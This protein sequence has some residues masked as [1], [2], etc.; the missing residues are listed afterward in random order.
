MVLHQYAPV[1][2]LA[3][4]ETRHAVAGPAHGVAFH[5]NVVRVLVPV[6]QLTHAVL[7]CQETIEDVA[8]AVG[9]CDVG[10]KLNQLDILDF[11]AK[12]LAHQDVGVQVKESSKVVGQLPDDM[13]AQLREEFGIA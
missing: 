9:A 10:I 3:P 4:A 6:W 5:A 1:P 13:V 2:L 12:H 8:P 7:A 11:T